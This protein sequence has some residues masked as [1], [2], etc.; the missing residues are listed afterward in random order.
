MM[1]PTSSDSKSNV[2]SIASFAAQV[3]RIRALMEAE[4]KPKGTVD[5]G[6]MGLQGRAG[7]KYSGGI[8]LRP[9]THAYEVTIYR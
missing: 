6:A 2:L 1:E 7:S 4:S 9:S 5:A 8:S 3:H